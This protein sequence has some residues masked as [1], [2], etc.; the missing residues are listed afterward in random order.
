MTGTAQWEIAVESAW[1]VSPREASINVMGK[2]EQAVQFEAHFAG[3]EASV[4]PLPAC[5]I[6]VELPD[7]DVLEKRSVVPIDIRKYLLD[8]RRRA[9]CRRID[10]PP[11]IDGML[12]ED[13]WQRLPD[14]NGLVSYTLDAEADVPTSAWV[15]WD[16]DNLYVAARCTEPHLDRLKTDADHRDHG[17]W[18]D[19]GVEVILDTNLD[20]QTYYQCIVNANGMIHDSMGSDTA[21][22]RPLVRATG[23][24]SDAWTVEIAIPWK[25]TGA[26]PPTPDERMGLMFVRNRLTSGRH[27]VLQWAPSPQTNLNPELYGDLIFR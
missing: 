27:E 12:D 18:Q 16:S 13:L 25:S 15:A 26:E 1:S 21:W 8:H 14:L 3:D 5:E 9:I 23:R 24:E 11:T 2:G 19:D 4:L 7:S 10:S 20:R 22:D 17:V 6:R